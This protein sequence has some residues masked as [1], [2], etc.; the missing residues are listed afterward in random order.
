MVR[1]VKT[2]RVPHP[3]ETPGLRAGGHGG[4]KS[5]GGVSLTMVV[6]VIVMVETG[7]VVSVLAGV[8]RTILVVVVL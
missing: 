2:G 4:S 3:T 7:V 1:C 5:G 6:R 8:E